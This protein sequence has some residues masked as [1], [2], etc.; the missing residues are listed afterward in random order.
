MLD[1]ECGRIE[2]H[3]D[4]I[5]LL[6]ILIEKIK[7]SLDRMTSGSGFVNFIVTSANDANSNFK[8]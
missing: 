5:E 7:P 2:C 4:K 8:H 6:K 1:L 3:Q